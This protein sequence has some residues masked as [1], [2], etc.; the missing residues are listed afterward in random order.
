VTHETTRLARAAAAGDRAALVAFVRG[1]QA[2]VWRLCAALSDRD[3][4]DDLTQETYLRAIPALASF[5]GDSSARTWLL[6]IA[7]RTCADDVRRR[8]RARRL[9]DRVRAEARQG[10]APDA[11][12]GQELHELV[13][14]LEEGRREAF[15]LTQLLGLDYA[16]AAEVCGCPIGTIRSRVARARGDLARAVEAAEAAGA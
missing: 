15:V 5:R 12:A 7:R 8:T 3:T 13:R 14:G 1:T 9:V 10:V 4:A 6:S 11:S 2:E 16:E